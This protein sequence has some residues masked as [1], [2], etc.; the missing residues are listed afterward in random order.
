MLYERAVSAALY[1]QLIESG[2]MN[3]SIQPLVCH[4]GLGFRHSGNQIDNDPPHRT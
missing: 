1:N 3:D 4:Q 2:T